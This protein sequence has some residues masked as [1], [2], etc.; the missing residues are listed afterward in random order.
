MNADKNLFDNKTLDIL[1]KHMT[2]FNSKEITTE[3]SIDEETGKLKIVKQKVQEK[4]LPPNTDLIKI[5]CQQIEKP[6]D[7]YSSLTDDELEEEKQ[8]LLKQLKEKES[9]SRKVKNKG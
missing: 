2:G 6:I 4:S 8:R 3:Y 9:D 5:L 1:K 7:R